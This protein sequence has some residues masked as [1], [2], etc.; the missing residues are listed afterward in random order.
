MKNNVSRREAFNT[1]DRGKLC[2]FFAAAAGALILLNSAAVLPLLTYLESNVLFADS[3]AVTLLYILSRLL[4]YAVPFIIS[5]AIILGV[6]RYGFRR[7]V[8]IFAFSAA[9]TVVNYSMNMLCGHLFELVI[10]NTSPSIDWGFDMPVLLFYI[11]LDLATYAIV[12]Y[13]ANVYCKRARGEYRERRNAT[14][15]L[16]LECE[17]E[18]SMFVTKKIFDRGNLLHRAILITSIIYFAEFLAT[19]AILQVTYL[20]YNGRT[21]GILVLLFD[22]LTDILLSTAG[23]FMIRGIVGLGLRKRCKR[24]EKKAL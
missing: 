6:C 23:Y 21:D 11:V 12:A 14:L 24:Q 13:I 18:D 16:G 20:V 9:L 8:P 5:S 19:H 17:D 2:A 22:L 15:K 3:I 10:N 1:E 7:A 4:V